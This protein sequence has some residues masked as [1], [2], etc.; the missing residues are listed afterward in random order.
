MK[1][2]KRFEAG[3]VE[4]VIKDIPS[5]RIN[6]NIKSEP[7]HEIE[8]MADYVTVEYVNWGDG[9]F[10]QRAHFGEKSKP[11]EKKRAREKESF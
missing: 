4:V 5:G 8:I 9:I 7:D 3:H 10:P 6:I 11:K 1:E 2:K